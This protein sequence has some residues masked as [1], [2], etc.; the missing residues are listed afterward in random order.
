MKTIDNPGIIGQKLKK[1]G[2][3]VVGL[4]SPVLLMGLEVDETPSPGKICKCTPFCRDERGMV[5]ILSRSYNSWM[6]IQCKC[7][8]SFECQASPL[9]NYFWT[10]F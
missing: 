1:A 3:C 10:K 8:I 7:Y 6:F 9:K 2:P 4:H 5:T